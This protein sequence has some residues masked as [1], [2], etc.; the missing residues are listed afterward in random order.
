MQIVLHIPAWHHVDNGDQDARQIVVGLLTPVHPGDQIE[1]PN[2]GVVEVE[3]VRHRPVWDG[4]FQAIEDLP[5]G[6]FERSNRMIEVFTSW[7]C[8]PE[9]SPKTR[10]Y[11]G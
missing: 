10:S 1:V 3:M 7:V 5:G 6:R 11:C 9:G 8:R 4:E 2:G